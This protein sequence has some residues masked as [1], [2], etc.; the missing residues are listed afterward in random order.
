MQYAYKEYRRYRYPFFFKRNIEKLFR[1]GMYTSVPQRHGIA[2]AYVRDSA[3]Y[4]YMYMNIHITLYGY[5]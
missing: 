3:S 1:Q 4:K 5:I 2:C